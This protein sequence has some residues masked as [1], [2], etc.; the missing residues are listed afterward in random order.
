MSTCNPHASE[1]RRFAAQELVWAVVLL[2][3]SALFGYLLL[4]GRIRDLVHPRF[5]PFTVMGSLCLLLLSGAQLSAAVQRRRPGPPRGVLALFILPFVAVPLFVGSSSST[6]AGDTNVTITSAFSSTTGDSDAGSVAPIPASGP[7][8]LNR[9]NYY[10]VY[11]AICDAPTAYVGRRVTVTGFVYKSPL[12]KGPS[13]FLT[14][15]ELMWCCAVDVTTIGFLSEV[16]GGPIPAANTWVTVSGTL[17]TTTITLPQEN[18][19]ST[20]PLVLVDAL[21]V[22]KIPDFTYVYPRF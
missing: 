10:S 17:A 11:G 21:Q 7:I 13:R 6:L 3:Y 15:R 22:M 5:V 20:V 12:V 9:D 19:P 8:V 16:S 1:P 18:G 4:S 2:A 14:A